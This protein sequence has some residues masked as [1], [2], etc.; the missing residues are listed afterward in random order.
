M[1]GTDTPLSAAEA[2]RL[3]ILELAY[4]GDTVCDL[5]V[6]EH[7]VRSGCSVHELHGRVIALVNAKAQAD[8]LERIR[9]M[10]TEEE[11]A[12]VRRGKNAKAHHAA[13]QGVTHCVYNQST[14][15][16]TLLGS[17]YLTGRTDRLLQLLKTAMEDLL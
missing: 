4:L 14:A 17:L 9:P 1:E 6:R 16:E 3:G 8:A 2:N 7:L 11:A 5:Y 12:L 10:L 15:F 13:P